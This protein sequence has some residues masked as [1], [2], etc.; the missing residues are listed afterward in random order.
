MPGDAVFCPP[1]EPHQI[2]ND[3]PE[4]LVFYIIADDPVGESCYY[5]DSDKWGLPA[6]LKGPI[7]KGTAFDYFHGEE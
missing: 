3:D 5:P 7:L 6:N 1:G 2:I 4:D